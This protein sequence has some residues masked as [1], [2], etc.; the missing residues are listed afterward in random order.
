M[1]GI[2]PLSKNVKL[3]ED[4]YW[5]RLNLLKASYEEGIKMGKVTKYCE[6]GGVPWNSSGGK[7]K[8]LEVRGEAPVG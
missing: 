5:R 6:L 8:G 2:N 4:W 3:K 7:G 1:F